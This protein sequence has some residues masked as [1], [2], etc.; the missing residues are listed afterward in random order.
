MNILITK[1]SSYIIACVPKCIVMHRCKHNA[2][3]QVGDLYSFRSTFCTN[4]VNYLMGM[5]VS[6]FIADANFLN[7]TKS[8]VRLLRTR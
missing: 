1:Y 2:S 4:A 5:A 6:Y 3:L 8:K 7:V